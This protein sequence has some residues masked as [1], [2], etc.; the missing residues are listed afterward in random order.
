MSSEYFPEILRYFTSKSQ[1]LPS[2]PNELTQGW[3]RDKV[4]AWILELCEECKYR[5][6][7]FQLSIEIL[8]AFLSLSDVTINTLQL[9]GIVS[10]MLAVKYHENTTMTIVQAANYCSG[11]VSIS[12]VQS[13]ENYILQKLDWRIDI[14]TPAE[15][16]RLLLLSTGILYDL[17]RIFERS[18]G[19]ALICYLDFN[20]SKFS[21]LEIAI[22]STVCALE[23]FNQLA[24]RNQ[25]LN[26]LGGRIEL[27]YLRLDQC[28]K[29]LVEK[30]LLTTPATD[31][32]KIECLVREDIS[33]LITNK[34]I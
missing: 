12:S 3:M 32:S 26:L 23:Q 6:E 2:N 24:F 13:T 11:R 9:V 21:S 16:S 1:R 5:M 33:S 14:P 18:D 8:S 27:D 34:L 7:T 10:L 20:L 17:S 31:R 15:I 19:F 25:W 28:K 30:L 4:T 22:T 29:G